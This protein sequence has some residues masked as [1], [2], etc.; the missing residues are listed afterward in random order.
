[1]HILDRWKALSQD[2]GTVGHFVLTDYMGPFWTEAIY[3]WTVW[4]PLKLNEVDMYW[5]TVWGPLRLTEV[6]HVLVDRIGPF[7]TEGSGTSIGGRPY[8]VLWG[9]RKWDMD[10]GLYGV[11]WDR[12]KWDMDWWTIWNPSGQ[13]EVTCIGEL[14]EALWDKGKWDM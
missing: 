1:M 6:G 4:V 9:R 11:I 13:R 12:G 7:E 8:G 5:R 14:Y 2:G 3:W 10:C